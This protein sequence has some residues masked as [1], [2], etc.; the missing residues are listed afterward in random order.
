MYSVTLEI[1]CFHEITRESFRSFHSNSDVENNCSLIPG[2]VKYRILK[3][4]GKLRGN[5]KKLSLLSATKND[6]T[7]IRPPPL[8]S[9]PKLPITPKPYFPPPPPRFQELIST[10]GT[11]THLSSPKNKTNNSKNNFC[12]TAAAVAPKSHKSEAPHD[13]RNHH[14]FHPDAVYPSENNTADTF[15]NTL[16]KNITNRTTPGVSFSKVILK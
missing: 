3:D 2:K 15:R 9:L 7:Q 11:Y 16:Q 10:V 14:D 8:P 5:K 6:I 1:R 4:S 13:S 12:A